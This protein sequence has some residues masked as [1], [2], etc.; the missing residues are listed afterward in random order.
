MKDRDL[1]EIAWYCVPLGDESDSQIA[2]D[3]GV[4]ASTVRRKRNILGIPAWKRYTC[5]LRGEEGQDE[6]KQDKKVNRKGK[7]EQD[8]N[9]IHASIIQINGVSFPGEL[10]GN[11]VLHPGETSR[12]KIKLKLGE[13]E[14]PV[15]F[16]AYESIRGGECSVSL[17]GGAI[18]LS[19]CVIETYFF[20]PVDRREEIDFLW[21]GNN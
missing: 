18:S 15:L 21:L 19:P 6:M 8:K 11:I 9:W 17:Y 10:N 4:S 13:R 1:R 12:V 20:S 3:L 2:K 7:M 5:P 14:N 16:Q